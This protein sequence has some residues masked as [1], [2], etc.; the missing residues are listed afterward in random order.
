MLNCAEN[1]VIEVRDA[2]CSDM[3]PVTMEKIIILF[4]LS[5]RTRGILFSDVGPSVEAF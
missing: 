4:V 2:Y 5:Q 1:A 3:E